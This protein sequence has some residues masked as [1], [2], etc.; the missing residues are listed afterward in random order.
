MTDS[1]SSASPRASREDIDPQ[2]EIFNLEEAARFL[3]VSVKTFNKVLHSE[4][5]P[6]RKIG[7]EWKFSRAALVAW[8]AAG[9]SDRYYRESS[10]ARSGR[11]ST[12][13]GITPH[14]PSPRHHDEEGRA[15]SDGAKGR[16]RT[17]GWRLEQ[18]D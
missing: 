6:A 5:L 12:D 8:V 1:E 15:S 13:D 11:E 7:R 9:R 14:P 2:R 16:R 4:S 3:G 17:T 10:L 18:L